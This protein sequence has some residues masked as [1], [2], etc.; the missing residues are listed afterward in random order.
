MNKFN[1]W[2]SDW[3][4]QPIKS[5]IFIENED[6]NFAEIASSFPRAKIRALI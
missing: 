5:D 4:E 3:T 1:V 6:K 2:Q